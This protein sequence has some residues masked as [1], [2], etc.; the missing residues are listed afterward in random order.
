M[1]FLTED[2]L[3]LSVQ[4][5]ENASRRVLHFSLRDLI[6]HPAADQCHERARPPRAGKVT[7]NPE[8]AASHWADPGKVTA[9]DVAGLPEQKMIAGDAAERFARWQHRRLDATCVANAL[10]NHLIGLAKLLF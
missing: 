10:Q 7:N 2:R 9:D 5:T 6:Q 1:S 4:F 3:Q 8:I